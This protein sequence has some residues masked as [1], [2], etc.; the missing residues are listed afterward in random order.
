M[1]INV[2]SQDL[3]VSTGLSFRFEKKNRISSDVS[4]KLTNW[5]KTLLLEGRL[6]LKNS[7]NVLL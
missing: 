2:I 1:E 5:N 6:P 4:L 7:F 3:I